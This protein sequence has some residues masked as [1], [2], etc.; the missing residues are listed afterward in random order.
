MNLTLLKRKWLMPLMFFE[1]YLGLS[2]LLF[3]FGPWPWKVQNPT[4][5]ATYLIASQVFIAVGYFAA[6]RYVKAS[7][8]VTDGIAQAAHVK[9]GLKFLKYALIIGFVMLIPTSLSRTGSFFPDIISGLINT[10]Q[11]YN[12]N[13]ERLSHGNNYVFVEYLRM[14]LSVYLTGLFPLVVFYWSR[15]SRLTKSYCISLILFNLAI[16]ISVGVNKGIAD[17]VVTLP[18]LI[19][20]GVSAGIL[21]IRINRKLLAVTLIVFF[22]LF[23]QFFG[24]SQSQR[25]GGAGEFGV[26]DIGTGDIVIA[27]KENLVSQF[28]GGN[29]LI[30]YESLSRYIGTGYY[31]LSKAFEIESDS[32]YGLGNSMFLSRQA[33]IIFGTDYFTNESLPGKLESAT[34]FGMYRLW[35]SIYPWLASDFGF[36]G[37]LF[38][39]GLLSFLFALS[40]GNSLVTL[41]SNWVIMSF[42]MLII[43]YYIPANNQIFQSGEG[44]FSFVFLL[45]GIILNRLT[46]GHLSVRK[47][48]MGVQSQNV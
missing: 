5:L 2:V 14:L 30:I 45:S 6:W 32:T 18:W 42:I 46:R 28:L 44:T 16:Y 1:F 37:T 22:A 33:N 12:E 39:M 24:N 7:Y 31:A 29:Q 36:I 11:N 4:I 48:Q 3:F 41:S 9:S 23:L 17:I 25:G 26:I 43:F 20:L 13:Y 8:R 40:W 27:D 47:G 34:G 21:K 19:Y 35:H 10:G 15:I 38:I